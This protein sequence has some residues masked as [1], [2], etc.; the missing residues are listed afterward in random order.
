MDGTLK[1]TAERTGRLLSEDEAIE[2][3]GLHGRRNPR[4]ALRWLMRTR[5]LAYVRLGK[6]IYGFRRADLDA[7]I[8]ARRVAFAGQ[9][10]VR[11]GA[12]DT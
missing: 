12:P 6:G 2:Y 1:L 9:E 5:R 8:D 11:K 7:F 3:L 4:G 10:K